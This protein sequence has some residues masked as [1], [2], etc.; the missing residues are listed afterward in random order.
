MEWLVHL[1]QVSNLSLCLNIVKL[2]RPVFFFLK[3][4]RNINMWPSLY[5]EKTAP[6][7]QREPGVCKLSGPF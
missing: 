4:N 1:P 6:A 7:N 2:K 3:D 5:I